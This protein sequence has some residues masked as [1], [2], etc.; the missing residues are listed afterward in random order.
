MD[1]T[2]TRLPPEVEASVYFVVAEALTNV[3]KHSQ[4]TRA[5][6]TVVVANRTL[7]IDVRDDRIA[8]SMKR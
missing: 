3:V 4:A 1:V 8:S 2:G 5:Q 7:R 6:V